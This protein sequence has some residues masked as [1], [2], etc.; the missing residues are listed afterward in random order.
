[1]ILITGASG[2]IGSNTAHYLHKKGYKIHTLD[3][4][5]FGD[6]HNLPPYLRDRHLVIDITN[7]KE[8]NFVSRFGYDYIIHFAAQ[9]S[10]PMFYENP[11]IGFNVNVNGFRNVLEVARRNENCKVIYASTSSLYSRASSF[12]ESAVLF[13]Q[14][15][16]EYTKYCNEIE[17]RLYYKKYGVES[18]GLRFFSIYGYNEL[19]KG[20]YANLV[21]QFLW[22]MEKGQPP[23]IYGDGTQT[24]DFVWIEDLTKVIEL[25][26]KVD[27]QGGWYNRVLNVGTGKSHSLN[28]LVKIL[29]EELH[30]DI[31]PKYINNP[32]KNYVYHTCADTTKLEE[33][34]Y[35]IPSTSLREGIRKLIKSK[36]L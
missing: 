35:Y 25:L 23:V 11:E 10:A 14:T 22:S 19:H 29:N 21:S 1:M 9:S 26:M 34:V 12:K 13:P 8:M 4:D 31:K 27:K 24:R 17:A 32:I 2:F 5:K 16:Y 33:E 6:F 7:K 28:E 36:S 15:Y 20:K 18:I 30:T 3:N